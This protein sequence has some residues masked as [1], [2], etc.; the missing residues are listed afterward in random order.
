M[1]KVNQSHK[2]SLCKGLAWDSAF[3]TSY[4]IDLCA[5]QNQFLL[6]VEIHNNVIVVLDLKVCMQVF[7]NPKELAILNCTFG[8][9]EV[10]LLPSIPKDMRKLA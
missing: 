9:P 7:C 2:Y 4:S 5:W 8:K 3:F 1:V 6:V 10:T